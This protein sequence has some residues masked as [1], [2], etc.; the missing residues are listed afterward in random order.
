MLNLQLENVF[1]GGVKRAVK[2]DGSPVVYITFTNGDGRVIKATVS[3]APSDL[4]DFVF[5]PIGGV[6]EG[7]GFIGSDKGDLI[8]RG[9]RFI[10]SG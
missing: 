3:E 5:Q 8:V 6:I 10:K 9:D 2:Q 4:E 7:I 1:L